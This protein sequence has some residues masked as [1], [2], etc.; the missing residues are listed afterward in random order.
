MYYYEN[1]IDYIGDYLSNIVEL[2]R[3]ELDRVVT[4]NVLNRNFNL[5]F[6]SD[7]DVKSFLFYFDKYRE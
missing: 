6:E 2:E 3:K 5:V 1:Y 7:K 4:V